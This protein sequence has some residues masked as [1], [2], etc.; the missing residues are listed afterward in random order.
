M[1]DVHGRPECLALRPCSL[2][3]DP[4]SLFLRKAWEAGERRSAVPPNWG[5]ASEQDAA[6]LAPVT[7]S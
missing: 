4:L 5:L 2:L 3:E 1:V 7:Y 6:R